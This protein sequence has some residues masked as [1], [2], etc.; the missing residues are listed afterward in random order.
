M[1]TYK[2]ESALHRFIVLFIVLYTVNSYRKGYMYII[3]LS[4]QVYVIL[5]NYMVVPFLEYKLTYIVITGKVL[6]QV[7]DTRLVCY[8]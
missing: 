5:Y 4:K 2:R 6:S 1:L 3:Y 7:Y 8:L